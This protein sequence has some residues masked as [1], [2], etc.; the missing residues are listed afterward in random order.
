VKRKNRIHKILKKKLFNFDII[1]E[2]NSFKHKGHNNFDGKQETHITLTLKEKNKRKINKLE[3]HRLI[4][5]VLEDE[6]KNGLHSLE[7]KII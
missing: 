2:D 6:F 5:S 7:I 3:V 1:I 4:N